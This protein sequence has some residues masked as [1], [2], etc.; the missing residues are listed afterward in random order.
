METEEIVRVG[1]GF[2]DGSERKEGERGERRTVQQPWRRQTPSGGSRMA[3]RI[4]RK[5]AHAPMATASSSSSSL[6]FFGA[7]MAEGF[8]DGCFGEAIGGCGNE[9]D[10]DAECEKHSG[11]IYA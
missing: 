6:S 2:C 11:A 9:G 10:G 4:S 8:V 7:L 1:L 5:T 3:Q